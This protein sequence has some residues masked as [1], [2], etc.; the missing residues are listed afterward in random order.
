MS[1]G[2]EPS[3]IAFDGANMWVANNTSNTVTKIQASSGEVLGTFTGVTGAFA[4]AFDGAN[5]WVANNPN[6]AGT[7]VQKM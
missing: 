6:S 5:V 2:A 3:G 4:A 7:T 1:V